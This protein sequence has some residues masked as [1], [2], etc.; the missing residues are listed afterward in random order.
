MCGAAPMSSSTSGLSLRT[1]MMIDGTNVSLAVYDVSL[2][3]SKQRAY[4]LKYVCFPVATMDLM[5]KGRFPMRA[6]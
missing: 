2:H 4:G 5:Y 6:E 3:V 1:G